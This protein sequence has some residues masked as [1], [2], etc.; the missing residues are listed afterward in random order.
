MGTNPVILRG[1]SVM[2]KYKQATM[3]I[4]RLLVSK[5]QTPRGSRDGEVNLA[6]V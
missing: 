2:M 4:E 3:E 1:D 5:N 6:E